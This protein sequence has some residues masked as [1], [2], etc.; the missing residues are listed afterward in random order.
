MFAQ[1]LDSSPES[2]W[3][4]L[5][6]MFISFSLHVLVT[7]LVVIL[8]ILLAEMVVVEAGGARIA[9]LTFIP[10]T[11][12][13]QP[14][15]QANALHLPRVVPVGQEA[16]KI[17]VE[18]GQLAQPIPDFSI[19]GP[20]VQLGHDHYYYIGPCGCAPHIERRPFRQ[21]PYGNTGFSSNLKQAVLLKKVEPQYPAAARQSGIQGAVIIQAIIDREGSVSEIEVLSGPLSLRNAA[22]EAVRQWRYQPYVLNGLAVDAEITITVNF[23]L[24]TRA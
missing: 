9:T 19:P 2:A 17:K 23:T 1:M 12:K 3:R 8:P 14:E 22:V 6:S 5:G 24:T 4:K 20:I 10:S 21:P 13:P 18:Q 16:S 15:P 7:S 11:G